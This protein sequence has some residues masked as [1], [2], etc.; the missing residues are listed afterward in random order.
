MEERVYS[1]SMRSEGAFLK[2]YH[3]NLSNL[4]PADFWFG[5]GQAITS[6]R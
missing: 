4:T 6:E 3:E 5:L 1:A 2:Q